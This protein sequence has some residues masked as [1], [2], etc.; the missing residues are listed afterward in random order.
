MRQIGS[1]AVC[2]ASLG[3]ATS[4]ALPAAAQSDGVA[5]N[6][7]YW[8]LVL[9]LEGRFSTD[10]NI[11]QG[12]LFVPLTQ[13]RDQLVFADFRFRYDDSESQEYNLGVGYRRLIGDD[14]ILGGY[15]FFDHLISSHSNGFHQVTLGAEAMMEHFEFRGNLYLPEDEEKA[16]GATIFGGDMLGST[17]SFT[18]NRAVEKP[19]P[20]ID[21][22][23]GVRS[24][25]KEID[26]WLY[27]G[28][29]YFDD[30]GFETVSGP[31]I[32]LQWNIDTDA[33]LPNSTL[34]TGVR[35]A[36]DD[37]RGDRTYVT[38][39]LRFPLGFGG[40]PGAVTTPLPDWQPAR[41]VRRIERD[42]DIVTDTTVKRVSSEPAT[43]PGTGGSQTF[44]TIEVVKVD[45]TAATGSG[46]VN[47]PSDDL[48]AAVDSGADIVMVQGTLDSNGAFVPF[49]LDAGVPI[50]LNPG[51]RLLG[52][53]STIAIAD[54]TGTNTTTYRVPGV[55]G[56]VRQTDGLT[57]IVVAEDDT[58]IQGMYLFGG[59][60][61]VIINNRDGVQISGTIVESSANDAIQITNGSSNVRMS[62]V[63]IWNN[64]ATSPTGIR[65]N[66]SSGIILSGV[67]VGSSSSGRV[68][69]N[70]AVLIENGSSDVLIS[71][72]N[73]NGEDGSNT[74]LIAIG[75][76]VIDG[77]TDVTIEGNSF[78]GGFTGSAISIVN[79]ASDVTVDS[80]TTS[81]NINTVAAILVDNASS[82]DISNAQIYNFADAALEIRNGANDISVEQ[83][84]TRGS[85]GTTDA[86][87]LNGV[88][89]ITLTEVSLLDEFTGENLASPVTANRLILA[90]NVSDLTVRDFFATGVVAGVNPSDPDPD[91][92]GN[93]YTF[94]ELIDLNNVDDST[95]TNID[96]S[97]VAIISTNNDP[98]SFDGAIVIRNG[99]E[100]LTFRGLAA[101][102]DRSLIQTSQLAGSLIRI[103]D[104]GNVTPI[105]FDYFDFDL[106]Q[107]YEA[108]DLPGSGTLVTLDNATVDFSN[109]IFRTNRDSNTDFIFFGDTVNMS[110]TGNTFINTELDGAV[111]SIVDN[112]DTALNG[113]IDF[114]EPEGSLDNTG[115]TPAP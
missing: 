4:L 109:S 25:V 94:G 86:I 30:S 21:I 18:R 42:I 72:L 80:I 98:A 3:L 46:T 7:L 77:S 28:Y 63:D 12:D 55:T 67:N 16:F 103:S 61:G 49:D 60:S 13:L 31:Q 50:N 57:N 83:F 88:S 53:G 39:G 52:G 106:S 97:E 105:T 14:L 92:D 35:W 32:R 89:D 48:V 64:D 43:V 102:E 71:G 75:G 87:R 56:I 24:P 101:Q 85:G 108:S 27:G 68:Y 79:G 1:K 111:P 51:Q 6:R 10:R 84:V 20:G 5:S 95:F 110:G 34:S 54:S 73:T 59:N 90:E 8:D 69:S 78:L 44:G 17:L 29:Y 40:R 100:G 114:D 65:I 104:S 47:N 19:L 36:S 58:E 76:V 15:G 23:G 115:F 9:D 82:V 70:D 81:G 38:V 66:A 74:G 62:V 11:G 107:A 96:L 33:I 41:M 26:A 113:T 22:E 99:S 45:G 37:L 93:D 91:G 112:T 2:L